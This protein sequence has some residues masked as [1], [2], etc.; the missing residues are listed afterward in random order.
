MRLYG[1]DIDEAHDRPR[2]RPRAGL[3]AGTSRRSS[4][5][6]GCA[7]RGTTAHAAAGRVELTERG[8]ARQGTPWSGTAP[9]GARDKRHADPYLKKAMSM[10]YVPAE[11]R[12]GHTT[13]GRHRGRMTPAG[14]SRC[15]F[16]NAVDRGSAWSPDMTMAYP[17]DSIHQG[18]RV[19]P[20]LGQ[21]R[22]RSASPTTPSTSSATWSMWICPRSGKTMAAGESFGS[23]N[24]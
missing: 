15:R 9:S 20:T 3:S 1:N 19:D 5:P 7:S 23:M 16:T 2:G 18:P 6:T 14:S 17:T 10:A 13:R 22:G 24:R 12:T 11:M 21:H 8:I 4:A